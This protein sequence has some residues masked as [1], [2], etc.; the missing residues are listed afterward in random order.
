MIGL[1]FR[2]DFA[3]ELLEGKTIIGIGSYKPDM[4]EF[5]DALYRLIDKIYIDT[6][7]GLKESGDLLDPLTNGWIEP[8]SFVPGSDM[9]NGIDDSNSTKVFKSVGMALFDLVTAEL[10]YNNIIS[11]G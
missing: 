7:D 4:R 10:V 6:G 1:G 5:P 3:E 9:L 11:S 2:R 8:G